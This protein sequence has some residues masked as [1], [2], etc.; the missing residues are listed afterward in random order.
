MVQTGPDRIRERSTTKRSSSGFM[1][2][3]Q[4]AAATAYQLFWSSTPAL[5][6]DRQKSVTT[7]YV[8]GGFLLKY[9][10]FLDFLILDSKLHHPGML[11]MVIRRYKPHQ[12][13]H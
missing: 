8:Y 5:K 1:Y 3:H 9:A 2:L 13:W 6:G 12:A 4:N 7:C 10:E 11:V